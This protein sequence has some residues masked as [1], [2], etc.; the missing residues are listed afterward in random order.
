M[1]ADVDHPRKVGLPL[2][3]STAD[4]ELVGAGAR[5][6]Q[7]GDKGAA[8]VVVIAIIAAM[9]IGS[10]FIPPYILPSPWMVAQSLYESL[11][12]DY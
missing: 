4:A 12:T 6:W 1:T 9:Q 5:S 11:T 10:A 8:V 7:L 3:V 2:P